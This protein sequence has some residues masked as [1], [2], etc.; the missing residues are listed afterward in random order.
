MEPIS[1]VFY[2]ATRRNYTHL[3][4][5][6]CIGALI[7]GKKIAKAVRKAVKNDVK[8]FLV[9]NNRVPGLAV[10]L[11]G[12]RPD[13][14][15]Y[16]RSKIRNTEKCGMLSKATYFQETVS[17]EE[18]L[19]CVDNLN[20]D[21]TV[22]G[23]LVQ[24]PLP[25]ALNEHE[26]VERI[27]PKKDVDGLSLVN[28]G[29]LTHYG[30]CNLKACTPAG[31]IEL[32]KNIEGYKIEGKN[33]VVIGRSNI[34]GKPI[35]Q[36]LIAENATVTV[37]HS[38]TKDLP[39]IVSRAD[40]V[41][42]AIGRPNFVKGEWVKEGAVVIDVGINK[43]G[44]RMVGDVDFN[45]VRPV[46]SHITPVPGGVGPMTIAMLLKNTLIAAEAIEASKAP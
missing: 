19:Q 42:A 41:V 10:I 15:S 37:C 46:A 3:K 1:R 12:S 44:D 23:I 21:E 2:N 29:H 8:E 18:L 17:R 32:L 31:C 33:A 9:K 26:V 36:L 24:L 38:R 4:Q 30:D 6:G 5:T 14:M 7:D 34:V 28:V 22:D 45:A 40:I 11:V 39:D 13:S 27:D 16:V 43:V 35:A 25:K 20:H